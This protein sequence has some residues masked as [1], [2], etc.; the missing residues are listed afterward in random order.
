MSYSSYQSYRS[1]WSYA[2]I[3]V[4]PD[5]IKPQTLLKQTPVYPASAGRFPVAAGLYA[6]ADT[7]G[8]GIATE[9]QGNTPSWDAPIKGAATVSFA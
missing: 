1:Y 9:A 5:A 2:R 7:L 6:C 4:N 3:G 8:T